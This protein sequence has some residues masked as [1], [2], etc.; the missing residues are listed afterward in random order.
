MNDCLGY[1]KRVLIIFS[2]GLLLATSGCEGTES[3]ETVDDT[4]EEMA[5]KKNV[6]RYKQMKDDLGD[7]QTQEEERFRQLDEDGDN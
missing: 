6:A 1:A 2:V 5:G 4:V 3:R 7:I